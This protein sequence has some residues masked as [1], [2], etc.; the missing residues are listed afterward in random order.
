MSDISGFGLSVS[1]TASI[2]FPSGITVTQFADD[3]DP[4]DLTSMQI[5]DKA[6]G[7][8]GDLL[9]WSK[10]NAIPFTLNVIPNGD[11]DNNLAVLFEA[12]R[13]GRGKKAVQ[14]I[15]SVTVNYPDGS[16]KTLTPGAI[17]DGMPS[18]GVASAGRMKTK[19][20]MFAFENIN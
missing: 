7:L 18:N 16:T 2:T 6:M 1:L 15:I 4:I 5:R 17:T 8:N 12:N 14:D 19:A 9:T 10:A 13:V 3:A 11:D 20:Y